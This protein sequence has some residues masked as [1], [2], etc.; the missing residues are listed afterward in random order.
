MQVSQ[1]TS[2]AAFDFKRC[3]IKNNDYRKSSLFSL[4]ELTF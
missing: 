3:A 1:D 4:N 2:L